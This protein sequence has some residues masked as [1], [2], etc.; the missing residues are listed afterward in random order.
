MVSM[1]LVRVFLTG[2]TKSTT[3]PVD[4]RVRLRAYQ[5]V[6]GSRHGE[7]HR[8]R[9]PGEALLPTSSAWP[10]PQGRGANCG[11]FVRL[12]ANL[13]SGALARQGLLHSAL[14]A[15]LQVVGVALHF[16]NDVFRLILAREPTEGIL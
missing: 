13:F 9:P 7:P 2:P 10:Q 12:A 15:R 4:R 16:L 14:L 5:S 3:W 1:L 11:N 6:S 8:C